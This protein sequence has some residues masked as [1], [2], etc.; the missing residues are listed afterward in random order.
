MADLRRSKDRA[1]R[2]I[3]EYKDDFVD[4]H[5]P[6]HVAARFRQVI[7]DEINRLYRD[8][9]ES[10]G[11]GWEFNDLYMERLDQILEAVRG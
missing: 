7:L 2:C 9:A 10:Q 11:T 5:L 6:E 8:A 3:L 4:V 1:L